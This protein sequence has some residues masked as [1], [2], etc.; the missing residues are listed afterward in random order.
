MARFVVALLCMLFVGA[1]VGRIISSNFVEFTYIGQRSN[2]NFF[3]DNQIVVGVDL[4]DGQRGGNPFIAIYSV[5]GIISTITHNIKL[6][7]GVMQSRIVIP[8]RCVSSYSTCST[9]TRVVSLQ[10]IK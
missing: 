5:Q 8:Y 4:I 7:L 1:A 9:I 6:T 3:Y 10:G 2:F